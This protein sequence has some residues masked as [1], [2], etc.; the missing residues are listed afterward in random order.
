[1]TNQEHAALI[2]PTNPC[3]SCPYRADHPSGVWH[4]DEYAKL[5]RYDDTTDP[6][7]AVFHCHQENR[8]GRPTVCTGWLH[9]HADSIAVRLAVITGR[10]P[11]DALDHQCPIAFHPSGKAAAEHGLA[12]AAQPGP[13]ARQMQA[14]LQRRGVGHP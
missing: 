8:T 13:E 12:D 5:A 3:T 1:M 2:I 9:V 6:E 14:M 11:A 7:L 10:L 4:P